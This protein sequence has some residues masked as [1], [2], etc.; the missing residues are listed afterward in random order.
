MRKIVHKNEAGTFEESPPLT[1][2]SMLSSRTSST[3][4]KEKLKALLLVLTFLQQL[5]LIVT[6]GSPDELALLNIRNKV[7]RDPLGT[8][9]EWKS[10]GDVCTWANVECNS[11]NRVITLNLS[12]KSLSGTLSRSLVDLQFLQVLNLENNGFS[13]NIPVGLGNLSNLQELRLGNNPLQGSIPQGLGNNQNMYYISIARTNVTGSLPADLGNMKNISFMFL[14]NNR[15]SGPIPQEYGYLDRLQVLHVNQDNFVPGIGL[16]GP[17]PASLGNLKYL[18]EMNVANNQL[19]GQ[20]PQSFEDLDNLMYMNLSGNKLDGPVP[21]QLFALPQIAT[22]DISNNNFSGVVPTS[23]HFN[24]RHDNNPLLDACDACFPVADSGGLKK[25]NWPLVLGILGGVTAFCL[26]GISV[27][28]ICRCCNQRR[29]EVKA[30]ASIARKRSLPPPSRHKLTSISEKTR[31]STRC[32]TLKEL[33]AATDDFSVDNVVGQGGF[34]VVYRTTLPSGE[35]VAIKH[36]HKDAQQGLEEF[37]NEV[38]LLSRIRHEYLVNLIGFCEERGEQMLVYEFVPN[39]NL[40]EHLSGK[41]EPPLTWKQRVKIAICCAKGL[42]YLHE[43]CTPSI[44]HRDIKPSNILL[45]E[46]LVAKVADFGLSKTGPVG[47]QTHIS[48]GIKGTPGYLDPYYYLSWHVG[49]FTDVYSFGVI[50]LQLVTAKPAVDRTRKNANYNIVAWA[51]DCMRHGRFEEVVDPTLLLEGYNQETM[52]LMVKI[53]LRCCGEEIKERPTM[54]QISESLEQ[55]LEKMGSASS[56]RGTPSMELRPEMFRIS[57]D[58][59]EED[60]N[61]YQINFDGRSWVDIKHVLDEGF[62]EM[63]QD[64]DDAHDMNHE[65]DGFVKVPIDNEGSSKVLF[66]NSD[67]GYSKVFMSRTESNYRG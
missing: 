27:Y 5:E 23:T 44:I 56:I 63:S 38:E 50:L 49:T 52:L 10:G 67:A 51:K 47:N 14:D 22:F 13:G 25:F 17:I 65:L 30:A 36:A 19:T 31:S 43:G 54:S 9:N 39:G 11:M 66:N 21:R 7:T 28:W 46:N 37:Y 18:K 41:R 55:A 29:Q 6:Q 34:G 40:F 33:R 62:G 48:T 8:L 26:L 57:G 2:P 24:F 42:A 61:L 58:M 16:T 3:A 45:D 35:E 4:G 59:D 60:G 53:A 64:S 20:I 1:S 15:L 12:N 32:F